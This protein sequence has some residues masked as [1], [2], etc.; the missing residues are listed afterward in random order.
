MSVS[1]YINKDRYTKLI[2]LLKGGNGTIHDDDSEFSKNDTNEIY[3]KQMWYTKEEIEYVNK[4]IKYLIHWTTLHNFKKIIKDMEIKSVSLTKDKNKKYNQYDYVVFVSDITNKDDNITFFSGCH[5][6]TLDNKN[7]IG[8]L[9]NKDI[10]FDENVYYYYN[11]YGYQ[12]GYA[13]DSIPNH[14]IKKIIYH[15]NMVEY[16]KGLDVNNNLKDALLLFTFTSGNN[17]F[18]CGGFNVG[19]RVLTLDKM[20]VEESRHPEREFC[21]LDKI[22]LKKYLYGV[23]LTCVNKKQYSKLKIPNDVLI[24]RG[25]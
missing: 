15:D 8:I 24:I 19:T 13:Y 5:P 7:K 6:D 22:D 10:L 3:S 12:C 18:P 4:N 20:R 11:R 23:D 21:F 1:Y 17:A 9:I 25:D 16:I 2:Y 14:N